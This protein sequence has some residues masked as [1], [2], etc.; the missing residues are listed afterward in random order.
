MVDSVS[1]P[2]I[3][4]AELIERDPFAVDMLNNFSRAFLSEC[5]SGVESLLGESHE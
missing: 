4:D 3:I 5:V 1:E 2:Q